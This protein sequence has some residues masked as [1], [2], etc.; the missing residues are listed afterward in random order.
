[1]KVLYVAGRWDPR[2]QNEYSG[3]DFGAYMALDKQPDIELDLVGPMNFTPL[4]HEKAV[5]QLLW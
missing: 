1:M 5:M 2:S 4:R 3:N